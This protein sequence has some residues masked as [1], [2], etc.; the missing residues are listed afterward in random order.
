MYIGLI[1]SFIKW[2]ALTILK[3][4]IIITLMFI[5]SIMLRSILF[6]DIIRMIFQFRF[7]HNIWKLIFVIIYKITEKHF[8]G[9][10]NESFTKYFLIYFSWSST[11]NEDTKICTFIYV[12]RYNYLSIDFFYSY[13]PFSPSWVL[14]FLFLIYV[15][16]RIFPSD[17]ET[18]SSVESSVWRCFCAYLILTRLQKRIS[19]VS[20]DLSRTIFC[21]FF[22]FRI[23]FTKV[24]RY[25]SARYSLTFTVSCQKDLRTT[26]C[27]VLFSY[28]RS[29]ESA[30]LIV[31]IIEFFHAILTSD[32]SEDIFSIIVLK[33]SHSSCDQVIWSSTYISYWSIQIHHESR[34]VGP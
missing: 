9:Y 12:D 5:V 2:I 10:Q 14:T 20:L 29:I 26:S 34:D 19:N 4:I 15:I 16:V 7:L 8:Q 21:Q 32:I 1:I 17:P 28:I 25:R 24:V 23:A 11:K 13:S 30:D 6:D 18:T 22:V 27:P 31:Q 33:F 3:N